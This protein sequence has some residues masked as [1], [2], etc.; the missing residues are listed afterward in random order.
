MI[1]KKQLKTAQQRAKDRKVLRD[2][3]KKLHAE[4][5]ELVCEFESQWECH[6]SITEITAGLVSRMLHL[7]TP[8]LKHAQTRVKQEFTGK[9]YEEN[10]TWE[11]H[12]DE[13]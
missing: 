10:T 4:A 3:T 6:G 8:E 2:L 1:M 13:K 5:F 12:Y 7:N 11:G 9:S